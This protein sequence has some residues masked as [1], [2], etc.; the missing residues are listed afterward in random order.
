MSEA[1]KNSSYAAA[2]VDTEAGERA[3][4]L[5]RSAIAKS[6]RSEVV[7]DFGGFAGLFD[8]S[9]FKTMTKPLL[10]TSTDGVGTK[11]DVARRMDCSYLAELVADH[12]LPEEEAAELAVDLSYTLAKKAYK[13]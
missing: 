7:G 5:M 6:T 3:V 12:R 9:A 10:A 8:I 11:I 2:G 13:L 4:D 1:N